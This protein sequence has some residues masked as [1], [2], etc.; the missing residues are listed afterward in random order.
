MGR[1][2]SHVA[3]QLLATD[4]PIHVVNAENAVITGSPK[5][6]VTKYEKMRNEIGSVRKGPFFPRMPHLILKRTIRGMVPYQKPRGRVAFKRL[7]V[8]IGVPEE[9][10]DAELQKVERA[11]L[12]G[13]VKNMELGELSRV[14]GA[15]F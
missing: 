9:L 1:L 8:H 11:Q 3:K 2:S 6:I 12:T 14:L 10:A 13:T 15:K 4:E 5:D 7:R